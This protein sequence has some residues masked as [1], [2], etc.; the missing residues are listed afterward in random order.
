MSED[1]QLNVIYSYDFSEIGN[2]AYK[3]SCLHLVCLAGEGSFVYNERRF[4][5]T[6]NDVAVIAH[7]E[8][9]RDIEQ[10][11]DLKIEMVIAPMSFLV[12]Q[13]P[14]NNPS[15]GGC[16]S[17]FND[18]VLPLSAEESERFVDDI[19][20][21]RK[22]LSEE[23]NA[24]YKETI[25]SLLLTMMYDLFNYQANMHEMI[26]ATER[27]SFVVKGF[28]DLLETGI[29]R[30]QRDVAY[31]AEQL[32]VSPKYLSTTIK[33]I[34]GDNVTRLIDKYTIPLLVEYLRDDKMSFTQIADEMNFATL[35]YFSRY[36]TK[37]LGLSPKQYRL[38]LSPK[39]IC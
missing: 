13:L 10:S 21:L 7:S 2:P 18:P 15:I 4:H 12:S 9:V 16:I 3:G 26:G 27:M 28:T 17:L 24:F 14:K 37:H 34:T 31:F 22:R 35:S 11:D 19:R 39:K 8:V 30:T 36:V 33:R 25:G 38:S 32:H 29:T 20:H 5:L 1:S 6:K 23:G